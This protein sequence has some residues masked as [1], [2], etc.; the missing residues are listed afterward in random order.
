MIFERTLIYSLY[1]PYSIYSRMAVDTYRYR[2]V[3][4]EL[5]TRGLTPLCWVL[6]DLEPT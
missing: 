2:Q 3:S 1:S 6:A 5:A 4:M